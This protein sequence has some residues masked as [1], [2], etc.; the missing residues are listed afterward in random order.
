M[1]RSVPGDLAWSSLIE[2]VEE[3]QEDI[4][5]LKEEGKEHERTWNELATTKVTMRGVSDRFGGNPKL[6]LFG[7]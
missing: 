4:W 7:E 6:G 3:H 5:V 1:N 2:R